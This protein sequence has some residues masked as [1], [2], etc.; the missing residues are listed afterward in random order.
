M[1]FIKI[2]L[3]IGYQNTQKPL[4]FRTVWYLH[5]ICVVQGQ[6][7]QVTHDLYKGG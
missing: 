3:V 5:I 6:T 4:N 2:L 7:M 1:I